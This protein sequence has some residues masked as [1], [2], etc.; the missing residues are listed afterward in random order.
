MEVEWSTLADQARAFVSA[1]VE[2]C[3]QRLGWDAERGG[4]R[5]LRCGRLRI[6][7]RQ[8]RGLEADLFCELVYL[9]SEP[10]TGWRRALQVAW[11][12][13]SRQMRVAEQEA[14]F[15][16]G[17]RCQDEIFMGSACLTP[18]APSRSGQEGARVALE[19]IS[20]MWLCRL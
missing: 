7:F 4:V 13:L 18:S 16:Q 6:S 17:L 5:S 20:I 9:E 3:P 12:R 8:G 2:D 15:R 19:P 11:K 1:I 14:S 10:S